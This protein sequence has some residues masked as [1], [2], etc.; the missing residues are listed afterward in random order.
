[1]VAGLAAGRSVGRALHVRQAHGVALVVAVGLVLSATMTPGHDALTSS[2]TCD[3]SRFRVMFWYELAWPS[4]SLLNILLYLPLGFAIG[5]CPPSRARFTTFALAG[6]LPVAI[7]VIQL[8]V[9]PLG[10]KC[11]SADA[12]DN[13]TGLALGI[14]AATVVRWIGRTSR[15]SRQHGPDGSRE[16][17]EVQQR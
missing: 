4:E 10:R 14:L 12:V 16:D 5:L 13:L 7:E 9:E 11:Q 15:R 2:A 6:A 1:M 8:V 17:P 3:L